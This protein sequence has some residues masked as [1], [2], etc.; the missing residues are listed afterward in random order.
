MRTSRLAAV[1]LALPVLTAA[2]LPAAAA[3]PARTAVPTATPAAVHAVVP[4]TVRPLPATAV[5]AADR[6]VIVLLRD[7]IASVPATRTLATRRT[8][9]I[10]AAQ[11]PL[12]GRLRAAGAKVTRTY[13]TVNA[14]SATVTAAQASALAADPSVAQVIP[15]VQ[16]RYAAPITSAATGAG[17]HRAT[18]PPAAGA[19]VCTPGRGGKPQLNPQALQVTSTNSD[20]PG[21]KTARSLGATGK[22]VSVAWIADGIDID[23]PDF[24]RADGSRVFTDY[25]DFSGEG[26]AAPTAG[27]ESFLDAS[28]IGAQGRVTYDISHYSALPLSAPCKIRIEGVA[29]GA[30]MVGLKVF[31]EQNLAYTSYFLQAIDYATSVAHVDVLNES[32]GGNPFPDTAQD[33]IKIFNDQAVAAGVTVVASS[34]DAGITNTIGSP[35]SDPNVIDVGASTTYRVNLQ[36]GYAFAGPAKVTGEV[37]NNI[38]SLSS[39]GFTE[40]GRTVD[41]VAPGELNWGVCT[42]AFVAGEKLYYAACVSYA[43]Q[44]TNLEVAGGT[45]ESAPLTAG[46]SALIIEAYRHT[47][48]GASPTPAQ[49]K[50]LLTSTAD[51]IGAPA[52]QQGAGLLDTYKAVVAAG[53]LP[54]PGKPAVGGDT[55]LTSTNQ[56]V[57]SGAPGTKVSRTVTVTNT[58]SATQTVGVRSRSL[59]AYSPFMSRTVTLS[60]TTGSHPLDF[61]GIADNVQKVTF[62]VPK[63]LNRIDATIAFSNPQGDTSLG[64]R[65][66]LTLVDPLNRFA[67]YSLPQGV[68]NYGDTQVANPTPGTWTAYVTAREFSATVD[69]TTGAVSYNGFEGPV[70]LGVRGATY[71]S[72][73]SVSPST[74]TIP[75]GQARSFTF[76]GSTPAGLGDASTALVLT[77]NRGAVSKATTI[78]VSLRSTTTVTTAAKSFTETL[79]GG[80]GRSPSGGVTGFYQLDVPAGTASLNATVSLA[81]NPDNPF[82]AYLVAPDGQ[83][84][85]TASNQVYDFAGGA[86]NALAAQ[87]HVVAP[88]AG[89]WDLVVNFAGTVSG[90]ALSQPYTVRVSGAAT[91]ASI[92]GLPSGKVTLK[93]GVA[94]T[95][96]VKVTNTGTVPEAYFLDPRLTGSTTYPLYVSPTAV[97]L[98]DA[99]GNIP[100]FLVPSNTTALRERLTGDGPLTFDTQTN[101]G[102]PD[103]PATSNGNTATISL[104][105][106]QLTPG[107]WFMTPAVIGPFGTGPAAT[108][109]GTAS[110]SVTTRTFDTSVTSATG[111]LW[112]GSIDPTASVA[113]FI[114]APGASATIPVTV[115][116]NAPVGTTV[117]GTLFVD[118]ADFVNTGFLAPNGNQVAALPYSYEVG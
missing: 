23:N 1:A 18:A 115:T 85:A 82:T 44:P 11:N 68:G 70:L 84:Q 41:L 71:T 91:P 94:T 74:L 60:N 78:P 56:I 15:D 99:T 38:S 8:E 89:R 108:V 67:G 75:A 57:A 113:P 92:V 86:T 12:V 52:E 117:T 25:Q 40:Q 4:T 35:A 73:G 116:P 109:T 42:P 54:G 51:D 13:N 80:N 59:G 90:T 2:A 102:G 114:V 72:L 7:Q 16:I 21:A 26:T 22:G 49:I 107:Y 37:S 118:D 97:S 30:S 93:K 87:L 33:A 111:D 62:T 28:S 96:R 19:A 103:L 39:G 95:V 43:G 61:Q 104:L 69:P 53:T 45:S 31:G 20:V 17:A 101:A 63:G 48:A 105:S 27:G 34:G 24:I 36:T 64:R 112:L 5:Q 47:H 50:Q 79:T 66:R 76:T 6:R 3:S 55:L 29:P 46:A 14:V 98:P 83:A 10:R 106:S 88:A 9:L 81:S 110:A 32:F 58:G 77:S 65:V 100:A